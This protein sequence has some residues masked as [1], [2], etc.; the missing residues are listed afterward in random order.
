MSGLEQQ[1]QQ[2]N[3]PAVDV[4]LAMVTEIIG[5]IAHLVTVAKC[6]EHDP[7]AARLQHHRP[8]ASVQDH[9]RDRDSRCGNHGLANDRKRLLTHRPVRHQVMGTIIPDPIDAVGG[10]EHF[11]GDGAGAFQ[12][13]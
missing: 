3:Q 6:P 12:P 13:D 7:F 5:L 4:T 9:M 1:G 10:N 2:V 11:Y 8:L